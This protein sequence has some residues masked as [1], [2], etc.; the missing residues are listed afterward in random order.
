MSRTIADSALKTLVMSR[1]K[2]TASKCSVHDNI[3]AEQFV[4]AGQCRHAEV[5][6]Y[7]SAFAGIESF[8]VILFT[9]NLVLVS[10][11]CASIPELMTLDILSYVF[12]WPVMN[13]A[14]LLVISGPSVKIHRAHTHS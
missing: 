5:M 4:C 8:A 3:V 11:M 10:C 12:R 2:S 7:L 14:L 13:A 6:T 1:V 9:G